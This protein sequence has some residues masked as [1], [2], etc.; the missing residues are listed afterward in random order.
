MNDQQAAEYEMAL[1]DAELRASESK[2][3]SM[4]QEAMILP[5]EQSMIREQ[6]DLG[7][8]MERIDYLLRGYSL[9]N[10]EETGERKWVKP[11]DNE[12]IVLS[13]YGV[14]LVRNTIAWYMNKNTLL[15]NYDE[16]TILHKMEDFASDLND[17]VFMEYEKVFQYP[18]FEDCKDILNKRIENKKSLRIYALEILGKKLTDCEKKKVGDDILRQLEPV[19]SKELEKIKQQIMKNKLKRFLILIREIQD[20]VH[21]TYLRAFGGQERKTL[22]EHAHI[23]ETRGTPSF[24]QPQGGSSILD[25]FRRK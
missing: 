14:H 3:R 20:A 5:Q 9:E 18:S 22:R 8:E 23:S 17:T 21:S 4:Q 13:D 7:E 2:V 6:L 1:R 11:D 15:S 25:Y 10:N 19:I 12:F 24:Q 16:E